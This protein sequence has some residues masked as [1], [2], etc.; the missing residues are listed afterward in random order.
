LS[1][2]DEQQKLTRVI[3]KCLGGS[4]VSIERQPRW[5]GV[6]WVDLERE[7]DACVNG[8]SLTGG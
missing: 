4:V 2:N 3:E 6:W 8:R 7:G 5:R 1:D